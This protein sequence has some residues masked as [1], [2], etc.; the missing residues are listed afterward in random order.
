MKLTELEK[1]E[2][3]AHVAGCAACSREYRM[4]NLPNRIAGAIPPVQPSPF[5]YRKLRMSI[6][7]E[8]QSVAGRQVF[9]HLA[10]QVIPALAGITLALLSVFA[11]VQFGGNKPDLY[12]AYNR[13]FITEDQPHRMFSDGAEI[14]DESV[15][16]ALAEQ[17]PNYRRNLDLK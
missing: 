3:D 9:L 1:A 6:E 2:F 13:V 7:A 10:R 14:T 4:L 15:L 8:A 12:G 11:Y 17:D 16:S 5:F